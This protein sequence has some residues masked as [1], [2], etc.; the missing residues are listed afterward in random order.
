MW[1]AQNF[2]PLFP[3]SFWEKQQTT[4]MKRCQDSGATRLHHVT[5]WKKEWMVNWSQNIISSSTKIARSKSEPHKWLL[6]YGMDCFWTPGCT[7]GYTNNSSCCQDESDHALTPIDSASLHC[8]VI[9]LSGLMQCCFALMLIFESV[10]SQMPFRVRNKWDK[11]KDCQEKVKLT[12]PSCL[13]FVP[14][15][16]SERKS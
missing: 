8:Q 5:P 4:L 9:F 12:S 16:P 15:F 11:S 14:L 2:F 3:Q 7:G 1:D 13:L 6:V 10:R